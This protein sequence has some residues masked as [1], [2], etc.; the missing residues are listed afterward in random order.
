MDASQTSMD[1]ARL[2]RPAFAAESGVLAMAA[3]HAYHFG[4]R[5]RSAADFAN[6]GEDDKESGIESDSDNDDQLELTPEAIEFMARSE[7]RRRARA[8]RSML[9]KTQCYCKLGQRARQRERQEDRLT[10]VV[11][12]LLLRLFLIFLL[13]FFSSSFAFLMNLALAQSRPALSAAR[14]PSLDWLRDWPEEQAAIRALE[15]QLDT[16]FNAFA[17]A[18]PKPSFWPA[19]PM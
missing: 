2:L 6:G 19:I 16:A 12:C 7:E 3:F 10:G 9:T 11:V 18:T 5:K 1:W 15:D 14:E 8:L 17:L 4:S 13:F